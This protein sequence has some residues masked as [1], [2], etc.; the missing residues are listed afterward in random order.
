MLLGQQVKFDADINSAP[1]TI[2]LDFLARSRGFLLT[3]TA[4][5]TWA[6]LTAIDPPFL[7]DVNED[8]SGFHVMTE[9]LYGRLLVIVSIATLCVATSLNG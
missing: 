4:I 8:K 9:V 7:H 1:P 5:G 2:D 6:I 3:V